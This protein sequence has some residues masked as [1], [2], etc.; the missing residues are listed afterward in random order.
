MILVGR[1]GVCWD[2]GR[3]SGFE[4]V[5]TGCVGEGG[6]KLW[7][8]DDDDHVAVVASTLWRWEG[9]YVCI[10]ELNHFVHGFITGISFDLSERLYSELGRNR[11]DCI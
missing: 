2:C 4:R 9:I 3:N 6:V 1:D 11:V 10:K 7:F 8:H 5:F